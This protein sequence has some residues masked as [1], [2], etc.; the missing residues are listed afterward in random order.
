[1][2]SNN[3]SIVWGPCLFK[4]MDSIDSIQSGVIVNIN[5]VVRNLI[6][7]YNEIFH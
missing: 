1:M 7:N 4:S 2:D 6:D 5:R 3:L